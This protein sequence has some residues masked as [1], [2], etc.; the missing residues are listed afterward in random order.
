MPSYHLRF[1]F[2][3]KNGNIC[4]E[5]KTLITNFILRCES[6]KLVWKIQIETYEREVEKYGT[7]SIELAE[8]LFSNDSRS[9][10][11]LINQQFLNFD[12]KT[13]L[14]VG[15]KSVDMFLKDFNLNHYDC[16]NFTSFYINQLNNSDG[17]SIAIKSLQ[18]KYYL[19][20]KESM[21]KILEHNILNNDSSMA[22]LASLNLRS[23]ENRL[24]TAQLIKN[25]SPEKLMEYLR[26]YI[27]MNLNRIFIDNHKKYENLI[28]YILNK[29]YISRYNKLNLLKN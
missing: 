23:H 5:L 20:I 29:Y 8:K 28:Y 22:I 4:S 24:I 26:S 13:K 17:T 3:F 2:H 11:T 10:L 19:E 15:L 21:S 14:L 27:H 25:V 18:K 1:R 12:I 6:E 9:V 16:V 7:N